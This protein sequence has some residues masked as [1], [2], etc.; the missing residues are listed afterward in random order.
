MCY[1]CISI[2]K[3]GKTKEKSTGTKEKSKGKGKAPKKP[4]LPL[5]WQFPSNVELPANE[6]PIDL[7]KN[8]KVP[9]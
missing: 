6:N 4:K 8:A 2:E 9:M 3:K 7:L 5:K 1:V